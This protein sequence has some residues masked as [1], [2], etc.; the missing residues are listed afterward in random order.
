MSVQLFCGSHQKRFVHV[1]TLV[2][3]EADCSNLNCVKMFFLGS[4]VLRDFVTV[5]RIV[6]FSRA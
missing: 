1:I 4:A 3:L 2:R 6:G 5:G